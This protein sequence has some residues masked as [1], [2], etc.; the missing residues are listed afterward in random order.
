MLM[1]FHVVGKIEWKAHEKK[2]QVHKM[3]AILK[4]PMDEIALYMRTS[5]TTVQRYSP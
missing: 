1:D 4:M 5:K 3:N 2:A